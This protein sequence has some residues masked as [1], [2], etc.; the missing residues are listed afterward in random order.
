MADLYWEDVFGWSDERGGGVCIVILCVYV[1][2]FEC[3]ID[4]L[5]ESISRFLQRGGENVV[6]MMQVL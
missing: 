3:I 4:F 5:R 6:I 1:F 2:P